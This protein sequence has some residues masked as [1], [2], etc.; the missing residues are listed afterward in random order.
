MNASEIERLRLVYVGVVPGG[1][2]FLD[3][4]KPGA[5]EDTGIADHMQRKAFLHMLA[6]K[7]VYS[8]GWAVVSQ[9]ANEMLYKGHKLKLCDDETLT[10]LYYHKVV[11][12]SH[13]RLC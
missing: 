9:S 4:S 6:G 1:H 7:I 11:W 12:L 10:N 8:G 13:N 3:V 2:V 5:L